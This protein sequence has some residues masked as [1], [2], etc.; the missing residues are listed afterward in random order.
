MPLLAC[1]VFASTLLMRRPHAPSTTR[2]RA[3]SP[4][5]APLRY[6]VAESRHYSASNAFATKLTTSFGVLMMASL[7]FWTSAPGVGSI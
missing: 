2:L 4:S 3:R 7:Y 5:P 6:A 1:G